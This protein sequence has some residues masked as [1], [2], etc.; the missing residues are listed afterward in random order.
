MRAWAAFGLVMLFLV[1]LAV[2]LARNVN[3][4]TD[5][6]ILDGGAPLACPMA[7]DVVRVLNC[8][9]MPPPSAVPPAGPQREGDLRAG[10]PADSALYRE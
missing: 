1:W 8:A 9:P 10:R 4:F 3:P 2:P 5:H 7:D 6:M